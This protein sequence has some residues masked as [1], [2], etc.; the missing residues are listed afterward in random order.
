L[1]PLTVFTEKQCQEKITEPI[2]VWMAYLKD[3]LKEEFGQSLTC[4]VLC[5]TNSETCC[6]ELKTKP[7]AGK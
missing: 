2:N 1:Y 6:Y 3:M 4:T 7:M 5:S